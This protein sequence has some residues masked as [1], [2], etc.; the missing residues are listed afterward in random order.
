LARKFITACE[1]L[2][3]IIEQAQN[4]QKYCFTG[5]SRADVKTPLEAHGV[6]ERSGPT[7][8]QLQSRY[9]TSLK[10][11]YPQPRSSQ[12]LRNEYTYESFSDWTL[13]PDDVFA[14]RIVQLLDYNDTNLFGSP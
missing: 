10:P 3:E 6:L 7:R 14:R 1:G 2:T 13:M 5:A 4:D 12:S 11:S 8:F 9:K